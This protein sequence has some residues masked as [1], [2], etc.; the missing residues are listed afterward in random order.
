MCPQAVFEKVEN[1]WLVLDH[2]QGAIH[3][4]ESTFASEELSH[5]TLMSL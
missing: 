3:A 5:G 2:E 1:A 4:R